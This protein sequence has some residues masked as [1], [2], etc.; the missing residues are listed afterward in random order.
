M[1]VVGVT[2]FLVMMVCLVFLGYVFVLSPGGFLG[3]DLDGAEL[4]SAFPD[5]RR[6]WER[7]DPELNRQVSR[8][9]SQRGLTG[10]TLDRLITFLE[11]G[12]L[13][14]LF[15][16]MAAA[17]GLCLR[18]LLVYAVLGLI[19]FVI[20]VWGVECLLIPRYVAERLNHVSKITDESHLTGD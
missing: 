16:G 8:Y 7:G 20:M 4:D 3:G 9:L 19:P 14:V 18:G 2:A 6:R 11:L 12:Y 5:W 13:V 10:G 15:V 1:I 17:G